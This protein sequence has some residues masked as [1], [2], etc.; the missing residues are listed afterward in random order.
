[1]KGEKGSGAVEQPTHVDSGAGHAPSGRHTL[2][3]D[4]HLEGSGG[5]GWAF[6]PLSQPFADGSC[7]V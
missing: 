5:Q 1:M 2:F 7:G 3:I 6:N 4:K